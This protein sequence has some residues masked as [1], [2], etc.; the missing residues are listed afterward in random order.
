MEIK[1]FIQSEYGI[2][3]ETF[4][5]CARAEEEVRPQFAEIDKTAELESD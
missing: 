4:V 2:S 5:L 3:P 1:D